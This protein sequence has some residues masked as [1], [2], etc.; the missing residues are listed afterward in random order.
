MKK[1]LTIAGSDCSGGAGIQADIKTITAHGQYAMSAITALTAQNTQGVT[2]VSV[3]SADFLA[4]QLEACLSDIMP[5]AVKI[6]MV[7]SAELASVIAEKLVKYDVKNVVF[8]PVMVATSGAALMDSGSVAEI[9]QAL[10]PLAVL[11]TPNI[12][13]AETI[14]GREIKNN[15]D[16][17]KAAQKLS[18]DLQKSVLLKGGHLEANSNDILFS[19]GKI[20]NYR[21]DR[22]DTKNTHGSGCVLSTAIACGLANGQPLNTAIKNGKEFITNAIKSAASLDIGSGNGPVDPTFR[23]KI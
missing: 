9:L 6:G 11:I 18:R 20:I 15:M 19:E 14:L 2:G 1:V 3:V 8:D 17:V 21:G 23:I 16:C 22:I 13:E 4:D 7:C 5:D 10:V 12:P